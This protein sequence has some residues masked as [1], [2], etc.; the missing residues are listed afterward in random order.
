MKFIR[1]VQA[2]LILFSFLTIPAAP[3]MADQVHRALPGE[4]LIS[5]ANEKNI[6]LEAL[7]AKNPFIGNPQFI[8]PYQIVI[9]PDPKPGARYT[10]EAGDTLEL[11]AAE[12]GLD[13]KALSAYNDLG[14]NFI[15]PGQVLVIPPSPPGNPP[16][17]QVPQQ[18][19]PALK[20]KPAGEYNIPRLQALFPGSLYMSGSWEK[21]VVALTFDD[22]PDGNYTPRI[23]NILNQQGVKATFFLVGNR[24]KDYPSVVSQ[25]VASGHQVAGHGFT[26]SSFRLK[27][28]EELKQEL[29]S[30]AS[31]LKAAAGLEPAMVRPPYGELSMEAMQELVASGYTAV[32]W[33]ADS[34]DWYSGSVDSILAG[35]LTGTRPGS[36]ILMH[37]TGKNLDA[38]VSALPELIYTLK[39]QG[40]GFVAVAELLGK[41]AYRK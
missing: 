4:T 29:D 40:Y 39:A 30:T 9:I 31:A 33:N 27:T 1:T 38:T 2:L 21:K 28:P 6:S 19:P 18:H 37:S 16:P 11:V 12:H 23:L 22:G 25:L 17:A 36:I 24:I 13:P 15:F 32:G 26:H 35:A 3:A 41:P 10:V 20:K 5:I 14:K 7:R 8:V 34:Q